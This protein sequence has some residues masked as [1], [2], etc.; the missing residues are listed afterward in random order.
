MA[1]LKLLRA[2]QEGEVVRLG[3]TKPLKVY[4]GIVAATNRIL[5]E[6]IAAGRFREDLF[7]RLAVAVLDVPPLRERN[8][9]L[10]VLVDH[11]IE[12]V[13]REPPPSPDA[14]R[15]SFLQG[16]RILFSATYGPGSFGS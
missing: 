13:N 11:L 2:V 14:K 4:A 3:A 16:Q 10:S 8:G 6:E 15:R 12:Q 7:C 9:D 1:Q 5:T